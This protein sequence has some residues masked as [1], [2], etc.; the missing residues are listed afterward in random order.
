MIT[1]YMLTWIVAFIH[2]VRH[3]RNSHNL[4]QEIQ[5]WIYKLKIKLVLCLVAQSLWH[6][7]SRNEF[8][9][10]SSFF[11]LKIMH[12]KMLPKMNGFKSQFPQSKAANWAIPHN[13]EK[14]TTNPTS[15]GS[16]TTC[17]H[18]WLASAKSN[19]PLSLLI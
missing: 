17:V 7:I 10:R 18:C 8:H 15:M 16:F 14:T 4:M 3:L 2:Q 13:F 1:S 12:A 11:S 5:L 19:P 9:T 6:Q